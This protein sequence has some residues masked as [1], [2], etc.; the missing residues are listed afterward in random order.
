[1]VNDLLFGITETACAEN[2]PVNFFF[3]RGAADL[4]K[5]LMH[6]RKNDHAGLLTFPP[7][8]M[9]PNVFSSF[10]DYHRQGGQILFLNTISN[11]GSESEIQ[12]FK[13]VPCLNIDEYYGGQL[14]AAHLLQAGCEKYYQLTANLSYIFST[15]EAGF[16]D[17]CAR[18]GVTVQRITTEDFSAMDLHPGK[19]Y[20]IFAD[21]DYMALDLYPLASGKK[22]VIGQEILLCGFDDIFYGRIASPSLTTVHQPTRLEGKRAVQKLVNMI[23]G[24]QEK[25]ELLKPFLMYRES[26]GGP[27]PDPELPELEQRITELPSAPEK[28]RK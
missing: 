2:F 27:R 7:S 6:S 22:A 5:F 23:Y 12:E 21:S 17:F 14:A 10:C 26:S 1:M 13:D 24:A 28:T 3:G 16:A 25:D 8:K 20:G 11:M 15:R 4:D 9:S 18:Q 19:R